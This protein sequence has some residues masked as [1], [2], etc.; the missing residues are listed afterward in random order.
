MRRAITILSPAALTCALALA[1]AG[2]AAGAAHTLALSGPATARVG[3]PV[4]Y[5]VSGT[6]APPAEYWRLSWIDVY[7][8]PARVA[9]AC[10]PDDGS[11]AQ[12]A[13]MTGGAV[14]TIA[15]R[16]NKDEAGIFT[17]QVGATPTLPG[18]VLICAYTVNEEGATLSRASLTLQIE[19]G[20]G[21]P[22]NL[23]RPRVARSGSRLVCHPG[24]WSS[25]VRGYSYGWSVDGRRLRGARGRTL[26]LTEGLRGSTVR[27]RVTAT[28]S[29]GAATA[30]S[31][32]RRI[33]GRS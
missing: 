30:V 27:C 10:P 1:A 18:T 33:G 24:A 19:R 21:A 11:G 32:P 20:A 6:A 4:V 14:L 17:N 29:A 13:T 5:R 31:G 9:S 16:P 15:M 28:G 25:G 7:A 23:H 12:L 22:R 2:P 26:S 8:I 3:Q